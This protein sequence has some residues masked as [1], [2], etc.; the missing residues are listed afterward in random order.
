M[1][2]IMCVKNFMALNFRGFVQFFCFNSWW[3]QCGRAPGG[4]LVF[5]LLPDT[6]RA[7]YCLLYI[8]VDRTFTS[9]GVD[10]H[11]HL[12]IDH[13]C[14]TFIFACLRLRSTGWKPVKCTHAPIVYI[15]NNSWHS[16][17]NYLL[18]KCAN[19]H[20]QK[21]HV[22]YVQCHVFS[23]VALEEITKSGLELKV[24]RSE[25]HFLCPKEES[26]INITKSIPKAP[27][28]SKCRPSKYHVVVQ[29][30]ISG[31]KSL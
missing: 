8:V 25:A 16:N 4:F 22:L 5:T 30:K 2:K 23:R 9:G 6:G 14:I 20:S 18:R 10:L 1:L 7:R 29:E 19:T 26:F 21:C 28:I 15:S 3:L 11:P 27:N 17:N 12:S 13:R 24:L 31:L